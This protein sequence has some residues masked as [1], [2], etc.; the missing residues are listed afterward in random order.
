MKRLTLPLFATLCA[1][2]LH[3]APLAS[4]PDDNGADLAADTPL[5]GTISEDSPA[6]P[7]VG[8][9]IPVMAPNTEAL[10][11]RKD[12]KKTLLSAATNGKCQVFHSDMNLQFCTSGGVHFAE[13]KVQE[14]Y[15][16]MDRVRWEFNGTFH[17]KFYWTFRQSFNKYSN[18][19]ALDNLSS[20][21]EHASVTWMVKPRFSLTAGKMNACLGGYELY[22]NG[23][24]VRAFSDFNNNVTSYQTGIAG[25]IAFNPSQSLTVSVL[26]NRAG[27]DAD[28][29]TYGRP[30]DVKETKAAL[31][32]YLNWN[33]YFLDH[34]LRFHYGAS[35]GNQ[36]Q[37]HNQIYLTAGNVW[38]TDRVLAYIDLM[39]TRAGLD[40][41]GLIS[42]MPSPAAVE[43]LY[44]D[45]DIKGVTA[46][47]VEYFA[48][49][50]NVDWRFH[51]HWLVYFKGAYETSSVKK[52]NAYYQ[53]GLYRR[54][55][56]AQACVEYYPLTDSTLK[57]FLH[58][59]YR[60]YTLTRQALS[61]GASAPDTQR[62]SIGLVYKIP[63]F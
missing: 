49:I 31:T 21:V 23:L 19:Y 13:G 54:N 50:A 16:K 28:T 39:Y 5:V 25:E 55:W 14:A 26:N 35:F 11:I 46:Q 4:T 30:D 59:I 17:P 53:Q 44:P 58:C 63:V 61:L 24:E 1:I 7:S 56:N 43:A 22:V 48:T 51:P 37:H 62:V 6:T 2:H 10:I 3:A 60:G 45:S 42:N 18:P 9:E 33:G 20:S 40:S 41:H 32:T 38:K 36:A 8:E 47:D 15:F 52:A 29:Y 12:K 57:I 34:R 27:S